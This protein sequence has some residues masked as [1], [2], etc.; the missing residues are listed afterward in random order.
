MNKGYTILTILALI[1]TREKG[2]GVIGVKWGRSGSGGEGWVGLE[3]RA[4]LELSDR[5]QG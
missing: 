5:C 2:R 4:R 1:S 3:L